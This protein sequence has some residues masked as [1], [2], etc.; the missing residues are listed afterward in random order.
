MAVSL[1]PVRKAQASTLQNLF[2]LYVHDFSEFW[3][4]TVRGDL[5]AD[6]LFEPDPHLDSYWTD[7][8]RE[9]LFIQV[10]GALAGFVLINNHSHSGQPL[11]H[12][13]AEFFVVRKYRGQGVGRQAAH[14]AFARHRGVWEAAIARKNLPALSFWRRA[15]ATMPGA[16]GVTELDISSADWNGPILRFSMDIA[17]SSPSA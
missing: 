10:D 1:V 2:Q 11:D 8:K 17:S 14:A 7:P 16:A 5:S 15:V 3:A 6:G 4:G 12:S 9:A 13:I